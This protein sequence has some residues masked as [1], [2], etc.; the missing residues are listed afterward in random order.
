MFRLSIGSFENQ[1][2]AS[3]ILTQP[4]RYKRAESK[5]LADKKGPQQKDPG[6]C[7]VIHLYVYIGI[8]QNNIFIQAVDTSVIT[9]VDEDIEE[10]GQVNKT[11]NNDDDEIKEQILIY[12][13]L[14]VVTQILCI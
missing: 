11:A 3:G 4:K 9:L 12:Q 10:I 1:P 2:I 7:L 13:Y 8:D 5:L 14:L 6:S